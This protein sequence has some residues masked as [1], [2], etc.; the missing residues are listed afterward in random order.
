M[1]GRV[2]FWSIA[3]L[4]GM[5][6]LS[7][8]AGCGSAVCS[9]NTNWDA[10]GAWTEP[11]VRFDLRYE[12]ID[13]DQPMSGDSE[14]GVGEIP[15][16]HDE[17]RT[18]NR[19]WIATLDYA[20]SQR[21]GVTVSLPVVDRSHEHIHNHMGAQIP[22]TWNFTEVG[23]ARALGRYHF[24]ESGEAGIGLLFGVKLPTGDFKVVNDEGDLAERSLQPGTGT[25]DALL[26]A[27]YH[28]PAYGNWFVQVLWQSALNERED[29]R[30]GYRASVDLGYS[31][32]LN[33]RFTALVQL[34]LLYR[35]R[36][37]GAQAEP[38]DSGGLFA[39]VAPGLS[40][41]IGR[42]AQLYG[43]VQLPVY[44]YV[45]GVQLTADWSLVAGFASRF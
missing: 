33:K 6:P 10:Q 1:F 12:F 36:D 9:I 38:E 18:I 7:A 16:H 26:G 29:Y 8:S 3:V 14:V 25:T 35:D 42:D 23:D 44:Q 24:G 20:F 28:M 34:N 41:N 39:H 19:N 17:V 31:H 27:Y 5:L 37:S 32:S 4:G 40:Y 2:R 11:G 21:F 43:F 30:P 15:H 45:N 13:Q 22:E